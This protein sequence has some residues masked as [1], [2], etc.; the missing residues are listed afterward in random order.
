[1]NEAAKRSKRKL[2]K[3]EI[4]GMAAIIRQGKNY[5]RILKRLHKQR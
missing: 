5:R 2:K 3:K 4:P 1:M